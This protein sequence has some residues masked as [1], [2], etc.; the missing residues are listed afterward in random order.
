MNYYKYQDF[1]KDFELKNK[2]T[3]EEAINIIKNILNEDSPLKIQ[4]YNKK[5]KYD[6]I[7][8]ILQIEGIRKEQISRITGVSRRTI[9]N[10]EKKTSQKG[11]I[12]QKET[13]LM[14]N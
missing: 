10:I 11:Q 14:G 5:E 7:K 9:S 12:S 8:Q 6:S 4:K 13:S 3:D 2:I 1:N